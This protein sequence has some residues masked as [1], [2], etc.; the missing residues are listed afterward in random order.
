MHA[1]ARVLPRSGAHDHRWALS[2]PE[3]VLRQ[4]CEHRAHVPILTGGRL[5][6]PAVRTAK[7]HNMCGRHRWAP[8][9]GPYPSTISVLDADGASYSR[10][11]SV[12][13]V[14]SHVAP[15]R[16]PRLTLSGIDRPRC[17]ICG[18]QRTLGLAIC[19]QPGDNSPNWRHLSCYAQMHG[20]ASQRL[21]GQCCRRRRQGDRRRHV[22]LAEEV[23]YG[24]SC[25]RN[26]D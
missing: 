26:G 5:M 19:G 3:V 23:R 10:R 9:Q 20:P 17:L 7:H 1:L 24:F 6:A 8:P 15:P 16:K 18:R 21:R 25:Y 14:P 4:T 12:G 2:A 11:F 13:G 22:A